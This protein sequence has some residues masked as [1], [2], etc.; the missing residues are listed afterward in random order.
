MKERWTTPDTQVNLSDGYIA[1]IDTPEGKRTI[2]VCN[3]ADE[4]G[5]SIEAT[6]DN[7][8]D[9]RAMLWD[10]IRKQGRGFDI[11]IDDVIQIEEVRHKGRYSVT[12]YEQEIEWTIRIL[13][14][15]LRRITGWKDAPEVDR[16]IYGKLDEFLSQF[17][18]M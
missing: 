16:K 7:I 1:L 5:A 8:I 14:M 6:R 12:G 4:A 11:S 17:E 3:M 15:H 9:I 2:G 18:E 10:A 13:E